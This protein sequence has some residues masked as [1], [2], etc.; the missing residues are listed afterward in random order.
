MYRGSYLRNFLEE[1]R[2][3]PFTEE[4]ANNFDLNKILGLPCIVTV[5]SRISQRGNAFEVITHA[6]KSSDSKEITKNFKTYIFDF[7]EN[8]SED[9]LALF[10]QNVKYHIQNSSEYLALISSGSSPVELPF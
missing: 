4:E 7:E 3:V 6:Q 10:P 8:Y 2:G 9:H 5:E 1:W